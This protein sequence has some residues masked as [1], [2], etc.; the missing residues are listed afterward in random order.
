MKKRAILFLLTAV[1]LVFTGCGIPFQKKLDMYLQA[2]QYK[3]ADALIQM[4]KTKPKEN[5]YGDK[6]ELLY[7]FDKGAIL[8]MLKD[9]AGST[10]IL[11]K[12][13][14]KISALYTKSVLNEIGSLLSSDNALEYRGED[15]E[16][17]MVDIM[18]ALN[19]MYSGDF[20]GA[21]VEVKK[22]NAK[23]NAFSDEYGEKCIYTEDAF[24]RYLGGFAYEALGEMNDAYI[25]YK[26]SLQTYEKYR[27]V[28]GTAIPTFV[29]SDILRTADALK[30]TEEIAEFQAEWGGNV[31]YTKA[32]ALKEKGEVMLVIYNGLPPYK[33]DSNAWPKYMS[34]G[35]AVSS[36]LAEVD[37]KKFASQ[38][39]QDVAVMA[40]KNLDNRVMLI[41]AKK[42]AG[43]VVKNLAKQVPILSLFVGKDVADV[44]SW[45]TIPARFDI[46][47][48]TLEPGKKKIKV[49]LYPVKGEPRSETVE[50]N[51]VAGKKKVAPVYVWSGVVMPKVVEEKK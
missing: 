42:V 32:K 48:M 30:F 38:A 49:W 44:R 12:A 26:K 37:G 41:L 24:A 19:F 40:G 8:Q 45:R 13:D 7:F 34:R 22:I 9:Y 1:I 43:A 35:Y 51:V 39:A 50:V 33:Y 31:E 6:N 16:Q 25:D 15:F 27:T 18:K 4:E 3:E 11:Q 28:Y 5:V 21:R 36:S 14:D 2:E 29:K 17:V 47:R 10:A 46:I 23:L 20:D